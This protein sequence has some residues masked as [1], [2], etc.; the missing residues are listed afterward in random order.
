VLF[1]SRTITNYGITTNALGAVSGNVTINLI[2][3]NFVT[4]NATGS[5]TWTFSNP[6]TAPNAC[7]FILELENPKTN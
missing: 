2:L 4:A 1:R 3:G 5:I 7:G 6:V